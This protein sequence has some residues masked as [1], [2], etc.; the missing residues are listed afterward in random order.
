MNTENLL[1]ETMSESKK[2]YISKGI[3]ASIGLVAGIILSF[4]CMAIDSRK[5]Q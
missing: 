2:Q 5:K 1:E 3:G 4:I